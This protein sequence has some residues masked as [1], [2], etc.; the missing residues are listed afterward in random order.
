MRRDDHR[1][2]GFRFGGR[3]RKSGTEAGLPVRC[4][5]VSKR[6]RRRGEARHLKERL[7][8]RD[9]RSR[10]R[11][12]ASAERWRLPFCCEGIGRAAGS[13]KSRGSAR[14]RLSPRTEPISGGSQN[15]RSRPSARSID[16]SSGND[17]PPPSPPRNRTGCPGFGP[18]RDGRSRRSE[19]AS[20]GRGGGNRLRPDPKRANIPSAPSLAGSPCRASGTSPAPLTAGPR[21]AA[22]SDPADPSRR[23]CGIPERSRGGAFLSCRFANCSV[24]NPFRRGLRPQPTHRTDPGEPSRP[25]RSAERDRSERSLRQPAR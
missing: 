14:S 7:K 21:G 23:A 12:P 11:S 17:R 18:C 20:V 9:E 25:G 22:H 1:S 4:P 15:R 16:S 5:R 19:A 8:P 2:D 13:G 10:R 3:S 24:R 6:Y